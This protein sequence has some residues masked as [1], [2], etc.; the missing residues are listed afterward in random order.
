MLAR[1]GG[2]FGLL[3]KGYHGVNQGD[4]LSLMLFNVVVGA[5]IYHW[6]TVLAPT[7]EGMEG[8]GL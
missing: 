6:V 7:K 1:S 2:Y 5:I 3:F 4:P 8:L